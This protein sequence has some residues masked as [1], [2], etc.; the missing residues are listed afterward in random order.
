L[1][2]VLSRKPF[3]PLEFQPAKPRYLPNAFLAAVERRM[4]VSG[5]VLTVRTTYYE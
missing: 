5:L 2:A 1:A 3:P 4:F